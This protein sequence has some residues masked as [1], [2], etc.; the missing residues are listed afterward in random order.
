MTE[1]ISPT[2][3]ADTRRIHVIGGCFSLKLVNVDISL[4]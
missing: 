1:P 2:N 4:L 3:I